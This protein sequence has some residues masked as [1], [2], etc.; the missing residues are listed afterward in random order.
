[1]AHLCWG[2]ISRVISRKLEETAPKKTDDESKE[3]DEWGAGPAE[4]S[5]TL[6]PVVRKFIASVLISM[7]IM[8]IL[9]SMGVN[10][11]PLLA[12][13]GVI[14]LAIGFGAQKI[15]SDIFTGFFFLI[16]DAFRI[17]E[18]IQAG[19]V[20]G[21]VEWIT[22]R[23]VKL[24]HHMGS[25]Q[26]VPYSDMGTVD[27]FM[28]GG[29]VVKFNLQLPYDTDINQVRKIIKKIGKQMANEEE[30]ASDFIK[31]V[32]SQ[33][34]KS[35]GDSVMTFRVKFT[36]KPGTQFVI[37]REAFR[38][39]TEALA[40]K[41]IHYAHRKV[42]VEVPQNPTTPAEQ[43]T[44]QDTKKAGDSQATAEQVAGAGAASAV[45]DMISQEKGN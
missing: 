37:K 18:Y 28:R 39:I 31:P 34:V 22:L 9:S 25:L 42:I 27:N 40:E 5:Q 4:R 14:G 43:S 10:I 17:G 30:Y 3:D 8:I 20:S 13:A 45:E 7:V 33:G 44:K 24:R 12:G 23:T 21:T 16:D 32:K 41:G 11:G 15:V 38:R 6:L 2:I 36:A 35:V 19:S 29:M 1:M 26:F